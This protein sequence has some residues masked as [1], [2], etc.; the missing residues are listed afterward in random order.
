[1]KAH[2]SVERTEV[3]RIKHKDVSASPPERGLLFESDVAQVCVINP[4]DTVVLLE[5][6]LLLRLPSSLQPLH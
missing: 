2:E 1:M 4:D 5:Q 6:S 3:E